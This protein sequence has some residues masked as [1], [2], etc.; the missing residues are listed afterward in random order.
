[1]RSVILELKIRKASLV[2]FKNFFGIKSYCVLLPLMLLEID[3]EKFKK[4]LT[5]DLT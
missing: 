5:N 4:L 1:M 2:A 3:I